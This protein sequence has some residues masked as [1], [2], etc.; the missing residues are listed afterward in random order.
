M[1]LRR[2]ITRRE[3]PHKLLSDQETNFKGGSSELQETFN[4]LVPD[5][6]SQLASQQIHFCFNLPSVPILEAH[7]SKKSA[8]SS[9][10]C[11]PSWALKLSQKKSFGQF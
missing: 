2:F 6:Q 7:G 10:L 9:R 5:L 1:S 4:S 8:Q 3:K 11:T